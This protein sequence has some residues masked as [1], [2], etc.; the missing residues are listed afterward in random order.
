MSEDN[1]RIYFLTQV[2]SVF[3][4]L[5]VLYLGLLPALLAGLLVYQIVEFGSRMLGRTGM[6]PLTGKI[7]LIIFLALIV[8]GGLALSTMTFASS[9]T[10]GPE[11]IVVLLQRVADVV[12]TARSYLP[13]WA[14]QY[15][16]ANMQEWQVAAAEWVRDNA[17]HISLVGKDVSVFLVHILI[18]MVIGGMVALNPGLQEAPGKERAPF[19]HALR[20]RVLFVGSAFRRIVFSQI[21]ISALNTFLTAI[22]LAIVLPLL[23]HPLPFTKTMIAVTFIV[24]LLPIIGNLIS[25]TIIFCIGLSVSVFAAVGSLIYL[26]VIHK[27][28]YFI[29]ARIIGTQIRARAWEILINMVVMEAAFGLAG[30]VAAPIYYAYLKD[31][32][33]ARKLI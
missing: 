1:A 19:A 25:N 2:L 8:L 28:E 26:I 3:A 16:P 23:G 21:R 12:D 15:M 14:L 27:L 24:G 20:E 22:F 5:G 31:E 7:I 29:N 33:A 6:R 13:S 11:S 10:Q 32:L 9:L 4:L 30:L 18:G 17:R